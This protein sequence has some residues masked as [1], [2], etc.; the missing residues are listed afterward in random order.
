[1]RAII[2]SLLPRRILRYMYR[3][4]R[5]CYLVC[6]YPN[7]RDCSYSCGQ[8]VCQPSDFLIVQTSSESPAFKLRYY[9]T[10]SDSN[11]CIGPPDLLHQLDC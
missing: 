1:V 4:M 11:T 6:G 8:S 10:N 7:P 5:P 2:A 3:W 9:R